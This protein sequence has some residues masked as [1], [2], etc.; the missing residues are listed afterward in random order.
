MPLTDTK[1]R[2][3]KPGTKPYK[4]TDFG[5]L[6]LEVRPS[7]AKLW[8][9]RYRIAGKE[10]LFAV[11][12]YGSAPPAIGL[13]DARAARDVA[14]AL[15]KQGIHPS[16]HRQAERLQRNTESSN[17]FEAVAR[18]WIGQKKD[19]WSPYY[20]KQVETF[21]E[22]DVFKY[23]GGLP[24]K[25][26]TS[27]HLL[28]IVKRVEKRGAETVALMIRQHCSA[29]FRYAVSTLR[30]GIDPAAALRGAIKRPK[31]KHHKPLPPADIPNLLKK[32]DTWGGLRATEIAMRLLLL[33]FVRPGEL[34]GA[35]WDEFDLDEALWRIPAERMKMREAHV[36][37]LSE[38]AV[39]LLRELYK[40]TGTEAHLF[41]NQRRPK[42]YM[43]IT[44]LNRAL[45]RLGY[46]GKFS[47]HGFRA[48]ASTLL[49]EMGWRPDVIERQ[50]AHK[51]RNKVRASYNRAEYMPERAKMMQ[52][53]AD[54]LDALAAG[55]K[56]V[57]GN[58]GAKAT[59]GS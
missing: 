27:A 14:R 50:L 13:A 2:S 49:N 25:S 40:V 48:A 21:L 56:V 37:P 10:N 5:G 51:E 30:A 47:S 9:Y 26:V 58:F 43:S 59:T 6:Y 11:G 15:V 35:K 8:R 29:I 34:R 19:G 38:Q 54:Y 28:E 4:L 7:G 17:T 36:V 16:H 46:Q 57:A 55:S 20:A 31:V 1:I 53:W 33:T 44:T 24:I 52:A 23:I 3:A 41:P 32:L 22:D 39:A 42:S 45:E 12:E 18:E